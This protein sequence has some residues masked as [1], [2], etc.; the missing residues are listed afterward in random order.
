MLY[1]LI[2]WRDCLAQVM[3]STLNNTKKRV[4]ELAFLINITYL[5][6]KARA[7]PERSASGWETRQTSP[8]NPGEFA[9][10]LCMHL[11]LYL[12]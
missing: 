2:P 3:I 6:G 4:H 8:V 10:H 5:D 7:V 9:N 11:Y 12:G 1:Q